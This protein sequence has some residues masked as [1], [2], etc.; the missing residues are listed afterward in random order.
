MY[1]ALVSRGSLRGDRLLSP[2]LLRLKPQQLSEVQSKLPRLRHQRHVRMLPVVYRHT[3]VSRRDAFLVSYP[4]SGNTWLKFMLAHLLGGREADLDNDSTVIA[5]V[6]SHRAT[7]R[8]LPGGGRL[9]K[10]HEPYSSPQKRFYRKAIYLIRDGRDVAVSYYYTLIR[11][12][13]YEGDFGPFLRLFL[14]GDVDGYGPWH[15]HVRSWLESPLHEDGS[16]LVLRYED[17]LADPADKPVRRDGVPRRA[18]GAERAEQTI[19]EYTRGA[20]ARAGAADSRSTSASSDRTSCSCA[21]P[22]R[23]TGPR[24]SRRRTRSS[25]RGDR[26]SIGAIGVLIACLVARRHAHPDRQ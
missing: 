13:L 8:V 10:S 23:A 24:P 20:D 19:R 5:D 2:K 15:E 1:S 17:M 18:G 6:G 11:R 22:R 4:K 12:G 25:S 9:I 16:L 3:S 7:P 21:R 26:G 14:A